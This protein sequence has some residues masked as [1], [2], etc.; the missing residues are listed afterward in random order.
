M[1]L[2]Y[3]GN[4]LAGRKIAP[5]FLFR[6]LRFP[7]TYAQSAPLAAS[8]SRIPLGWGVPPFGGK[9]ASPLAI[10]APGIPLRW[11]VFEPDENHSLA[12]RGLL[13]LSFRIALNPVCDDLPMEKT[14]KA[15]IGAG[16]NKQAK[17]IR[18]IDIVSAELEAGQRE[19]QVPVPFIDHIALIM[20]AR[21]TAARYVF[22]FQESDRIRQF[23]GVYHSRLSQGRKDNAAIFSRTRSN[24]HAILKYGKSI[25][26]TFA[27]LKRLLIASH[28]LPESIQR[29]APAEL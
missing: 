16:E 9:F 7:H 3:A 21:R 27:S 28:C 1:L 11:P 23:D 25:K 5:K 15:A 29:V 8:A 17:H 10:D 14:D 12:D 26:K 20:A 2:C 22:G 13:D 24:P 18:A 4:S 19:M 6:K